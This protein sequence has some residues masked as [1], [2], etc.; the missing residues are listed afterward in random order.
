MRDVRSDL[1]LALRLADLADGISI[2]AFTE[3]AFEHS[4]KPDGTPTVSVEEAI[5]D[6]L[7]RVLAREC[8]EVGFLGEERGQSGDASTCWIVDPIDGTRAFI[9]GGTAWGT[10][11][12]LQVDGDL[13]L[14]VTSAPAW[15]SRWW[16]AVGQGAWTSSSQSDVR[17]LQIS[18]PYKNQR[19]KWG[20]HPPLDAMSDGW[21]R[22]ASG[23]Y[24]IGDYIEP[25]PHAVLMVMEGQI[26]AA[27]QLEGAAWDY[28][29]FAAIVH[30]VGGRFGYL[31]YS[32]VLGGV[33]PA[34]FTNGITHDEAISA[35]V[36]FKADG[37]PSQPDC[38]RS[39]VGRRFS[40]VADRHHR[41][42]YLR[43]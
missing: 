30:A 3:G 40:L 21:R 35:L 23:L 39:P 11:I 33:R 42:S 9:A 31:D 28:A 37:W 18:T 19:L 22:L 14:G 20:C 43:H 38:P 2:A 27:L 36:Q 7:R 16:G 15:G 29:A 26:E 1:Q 25:N 10:Q 41:D 24:D 34:L 5:E 12:A 6:D 32:T 8:P 13:T 17:T 4:I